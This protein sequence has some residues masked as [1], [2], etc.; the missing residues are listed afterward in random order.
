MVE[1]LD[2]ITTN[3]IQNAHKMGEDGF[4]N[5]KFELMEKV[6]NKHGVKVEPKF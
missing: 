6:R 5:S 1:G 3:C 2:A 4:P